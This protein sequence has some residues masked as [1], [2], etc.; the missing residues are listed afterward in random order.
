MAFNEREPK[1]TKQ[2]YWADGADG[3]LEQNPIV[4]QFSN[5]LRELYNQQVYESRVI[6]A[7]FAWSGVKTNSPHFEQS[8]FCRSSVRSLP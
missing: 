1:E 6:Y 4:G 8:L 7:R 2:I 5:E 3:V